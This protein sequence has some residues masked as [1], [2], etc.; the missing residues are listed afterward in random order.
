MLNVKKISK[1]DECKEIKKLQNSVSCAQIII[2]WLLLGI[3]HEVF[4]VPLK[5]GKKSI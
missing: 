1:K 3:A 4:L 5:E 2:L